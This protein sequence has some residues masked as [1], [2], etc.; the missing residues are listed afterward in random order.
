[1]A[2][3]NVSVQF[4]GGFLSD[5]ILLNLCH[6]H[7]Q[8]FGEIKNELVFLRTRPERLLSER[9][10]RIGAATIQAKALIRSPRKKTKTKTKRMYDCA[11]QEL[12][13]R[14]QENPDG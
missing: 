14:F 10:R 9:P 6:Y 5:I 4:N 3:N 12:L 7:Q 2:I 11:N 1:M 8:N 13:Q